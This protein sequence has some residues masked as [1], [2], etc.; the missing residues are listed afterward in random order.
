MVHV[1]FPI[2]MPI[3]LG[4]SRKDS[5][6]KRIVFRLA[7]LSLLLCLNRHDPDTTLAVATPTDYNM[8]R[9]NMFRRDQERVQRPTLPPTR[10][11]EQ[12]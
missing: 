10:I 12:L 2:I 5:L 11:A 8:S 9:G 4:F 3:V 7:L 1:G 6:I